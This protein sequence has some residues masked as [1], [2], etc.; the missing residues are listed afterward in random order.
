LSDGSTMPAIDPLVTIRPAGGL[1][2]R[3][4]RRG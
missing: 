2:L 4:T 3:V 1:R